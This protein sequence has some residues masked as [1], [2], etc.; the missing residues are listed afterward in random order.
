MGKILSL[1][2]FSLK[3]RQF[4]IG[5][6]IA[7][8][9]ISCK[10]GQNLGQPAKDAQVQPVFIRNHFYFTKKARSVEI[11]FKYVN[12]L[13]V[14]PLRINGSDT[15][16]FI[17]D[18]GVKTALI[19][20]LSH[21]ESVQ[22]NDTRRIKIRGL[23][24]G[25]DLDALLSYGNR[26]DI[27]TNIRGDNHDI[28]I[29]TEDI[30]FL[31][32]KL[33]MRV[34]GIIGYDVFKNFIAEIRYEERKIVLHRPEKYKRRPPGIMLPLIIEEGKPYVETFIEQE[35]GQRLKVKLLVDTGA[36]YA[37]SLDRL[38]DPGIVLPPKTVDT[39]LGRGLSGD[40]HGQLGRLKSLELGKYKF[41]NFTA[42]YPDSASLRQVAGAVH[43]NG[44]L[45]ADILK[46]FHVTL[47]YPNSRLYL[48]PNADYKRP[49]FYN[50]SGMEVV[51]PIP[52]LPS[53]TVSEVSA[54]SPAAE[55]GVQR[56]DEVLELNGRKVYFLTLNDFT[57]LFHS[58]P[59]KKVTLTVKRGEQVLKMS[60][61]LRQPI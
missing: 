38:S 36:S 27:S 45:G 60:F 43:R 8:S 31:S 41:K 7:H 4:V 47:D 54:K 15:M 39:Y 51:A 35:N 32:T 42:S 3:W 14:I 56:S 26:F 44:L 55:A 34:S 10:S 30:F 16:R 28:L 49:F 21:G 6:A 9:L 13:M 22:I 59:G 24:D 17:L 23:G 57:E 20:G 18:T 37:L 25:S 33:G 11:P 52:G 19:T 1:L 58:K 29:L 40:I 46:R 12:N 5:L 48:K 53:F 61:V 50:L 2:P